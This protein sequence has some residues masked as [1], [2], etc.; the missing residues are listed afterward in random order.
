MILNISQPYR[1]P[2]PVTGIALFASWMQLTYHRGFLYFRE[3]THYPVRCFILFLLTELSAATNRTTSSSQLTLRLPTCHWLLL[4]YCRYSVK[5]VTGRRGSKQLS[6]WCSVSWHCVIN[7][8][9]TDSF[10][11]R[12]GNI[13]KH[14]S[15]PSI[16]CYEK[17]VTENYFFLFYEVT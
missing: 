16:P 12:R 6:M 13:L 4:H 5:S 15:L 17:P 8:T 14:F 2:R 1:P 3:T 10:Q 7:R 11:L 9:G